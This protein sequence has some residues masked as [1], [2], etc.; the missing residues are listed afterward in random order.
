[1]PRSV[2]CAAA[3]VAALAGSAAAQSSISPVPAD[4]KVRLESMA[5]RPG[6]PV[7]WV[8]IDASGRARLSRI[9]EGGQD[10]PE[11]SLSISA[12]A[13]A[14]LWA[15]IQ[16]ERFFELQPVYRDPD[17]HDG[18]MAKITLTAGGRTHAVR[19]V[20]IRVLAFDRVTLA[21]DNELPKPR[22]I[23]YN[24]LRVGDYKAVER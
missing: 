21:I 17:I 5:R 16:A 13:I 6:S 19:T 20:N 1:M 7:A 4:F 18:D 8:E 14:R 15:R 2:I 10:L 3:F 22:R 9:Q 11:A 12:A 23:Q 24:A